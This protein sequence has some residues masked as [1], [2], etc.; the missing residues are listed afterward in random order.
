MDDPRRG[1]RDFGPAPHRRL[2][3]LV[4]HLVEG[5][6][7]TRAAHAVAGPDCS[8][9]ASVR[10]RVAGGEAVVVGIRAWPVGAARDGLEA[11]VCAPRCAGAS[12]PTGRVG[13]S[14]PVRS[15]RDLETP[16]IGAVEQLI[17]FV[18]VGAGDSGSAPG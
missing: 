6:K 16:L 17:D 11:P 4:D 9:P 14:G 12:R 18:T 1:G 3:I 10:R 15:Y 2:G 7:E 8:S 13:C 5:S